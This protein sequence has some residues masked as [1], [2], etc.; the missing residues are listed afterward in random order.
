MLMERNL[1]DTEEG[2]SKGQLIEEFLTLFIA[3]TDTTSHLMGM[4]LYYLS[5][6]PEVQGRL[7]DELFSLKR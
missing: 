2:L 4:L 7:R 1:I 5:I 3:G 6:N